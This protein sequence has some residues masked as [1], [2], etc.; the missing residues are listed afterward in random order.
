M[1]LLAVDDAH[2]V[3][4]TRNPASRVQRTHINGVLLQ[5]KY[6][7]CLDCPVPSRLSHIYLH[8]LIL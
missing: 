7:L 2:A 1:G 8:E 3:Y 4:G 6:A 5:R